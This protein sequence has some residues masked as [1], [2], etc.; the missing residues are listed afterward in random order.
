MYGIWPAAFSYLVKR[1]LIGLT[2]RWLTEKA[3][4]LLQLHMPQ[5]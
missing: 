5:S 3:H 4:K 2:Q 1:E